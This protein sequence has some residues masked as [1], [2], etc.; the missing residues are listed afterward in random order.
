VRIVQPPRDGV[1]HTRNA[2]LSDAS[3]EEGISL[4]GAEGV[5]LD[6]GVR[7]RGALT[8]EIEVYVGAERRRVEQNE[9][10]VYAQLGL[11]R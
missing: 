5:V 1:E 8:D 9:P 3:S 2:V 10:D 7:R 4:E 11:D 6:F